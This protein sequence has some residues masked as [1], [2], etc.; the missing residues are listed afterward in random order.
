[1]GNPENVLE[2]GCGTME[3]RKHLDCD[4]VGLDLEPKFEVDVVADGHNLPFK[5]NAFDTV[6]T[7][8]CLQHLSS[9]EKALQEIMRVAEN[10]IILAERT[11]EKPTKVVFA[12]ENGV[13]RRRFNKADLIETLKGWGEVSFKLSGADNRV[14]LY[15]GEASY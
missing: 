14:G 9:Y 7:K 12:N 6:V 2:V 13:I 5:D 4:Y 11:W 15:L 10:Q 8:N 1:M 3:L